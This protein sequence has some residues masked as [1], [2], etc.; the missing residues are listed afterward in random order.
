MD[1]E[2]EKKIEELC[3]DVVQGRSAV[4]YVEPDPKIVNSHPGPESKAIFLGEE[5]K[6]FAEAVLME[7]LRAKKPLARYRILIV[8]D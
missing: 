6:G 8:V 1:A 5:A 2:T 4:A 7:S 3:N